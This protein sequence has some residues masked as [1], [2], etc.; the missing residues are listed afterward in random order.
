MVF[1]ELA[2]WCRSVFKFGVFNAMQSQCFDTVCVV[3]L[4]V[5]TLDRL[6]YYQAMNTDSNMV[7]FR[8]V[9]A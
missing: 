1:D 8:T 2:D 9:V 4:F 7:R 3:P 6:T 5:H